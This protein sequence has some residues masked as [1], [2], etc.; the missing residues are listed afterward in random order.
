M[1]MTFDDL[2]AVGAEGLKDQDL[3][4]ILQHTSGVNKN[5]MASQLLQYISA[6]SCGQ[7]CGT[8]PSNKSL[9]AATGNDIGVW[10]WTTNDP[11]TAPSGFPYTYAIVEILKHERVAGNDATY[12]LVQRLNV[13]DAIYQRMKT[14]STE[15]W[16]R[17]KRFD[18]EF[19][20]RFG[21]D[22]FESNSATGFK[23]VQFS[24]AF[25][26]PPKVIVSPI[27]PS[28]GTTTVAQV[29]AVDVNSFNVRLV[30]VDVPDPTTATCPTVSIDEVGGDVVLYN[31]PELTAFINRY[32]IFTTQNCGFYWV[33]IAQRTVEYGSETS[34]SSQG[35]E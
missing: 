30:S 32:C 35:G 10:K 29:G 5:I 15:T 25:V 26:T 8:W 34:I 12:D 21:S 19:E 1:G 23:E 20:I 14:S 24:P 4:A 33:A 7:C 2:T 13:G 9:D 11:S 6:S 22:I 27:N 17:L 31:G 3:F 16:S 28:V 18:A